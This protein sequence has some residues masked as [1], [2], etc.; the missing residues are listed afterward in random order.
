MGPGSGGWLIRLVYRDGL[1]GWYIVDGYTG[2]F[3]GLAYRGWP[4]GADL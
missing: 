4:I 2:R 1:L 3:K